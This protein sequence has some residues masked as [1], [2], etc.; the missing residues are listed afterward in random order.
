MIYLPF[1]TEGI[2]IKNFGKNNEFYFCELNKE[3]LN[4]F[5]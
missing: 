1:D 4:F 5:V 2:S 3:N